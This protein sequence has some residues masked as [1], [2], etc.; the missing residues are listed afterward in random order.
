M[1]RQ[2]NNLHLRPKNAYWALPQNN[3]R[4]QVPYILPLTTIV[5]TRKRFRPQRRAKPGAHTHTG[6]TATAYQTVGLRRGTYQTVG[7]E[8]RAGR[9]GFAPRAALASFS[10]SIKH[11]ARCLLA[12]ILPTRIGTCASAGHEPGPARPRHALRFMR[13]QGAFTSL[14]RPLACFCA[15]IHTTYAIL[16]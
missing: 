8:E 12:S 9:R 3:G 7:F 14:H 16:V 4:A 11:G 13:F 10:L 5:H 6:R 15:R 2:R 1:M